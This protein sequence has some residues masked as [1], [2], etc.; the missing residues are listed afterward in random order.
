[1][2]TETNAYYLGCVT[3]TLDLLEEIVLAAIAP[4]TFSQLSDETALATNM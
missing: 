2:D 1:M 3:Q 4:T